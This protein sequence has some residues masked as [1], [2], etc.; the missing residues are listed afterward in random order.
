MLEVFLAGMKY[1]LFRY[2][3]DITK[4]IIKDILFRYNQLLTSSYGP[5]IARKPLLS[6]PI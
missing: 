2:Y 1:I 6:S 4:D 5:D 3:K